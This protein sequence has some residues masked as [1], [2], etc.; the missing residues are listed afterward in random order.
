MATNSCNF[1]DNKLITDC[2]NQLK[3][4]LTVVATDFIRSV[5]TLD[6]AVAALTAINASAVSATEL[7]RLP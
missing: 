1:D 2:S 7:Q 3:C 4:H 6:V 5:P